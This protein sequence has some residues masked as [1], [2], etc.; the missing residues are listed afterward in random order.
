MAI[1]VSADRKAPQVSG[2][3]DDSSRSLVIL[4]VMKISQSELFK[5]PFIVDMNIE[6]LVFYMYR[7]IFEQFH[8]PR[9]GKSNHQRQ[10]T[11]DVSAAAV[12]ANRK[13]FV[14]YQRSIHM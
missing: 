11:C 7:K 1:L 8:G 13:H 4:S 10:T 12:S 6:Y 2:N 9:L 5:F 14:Q 3:S